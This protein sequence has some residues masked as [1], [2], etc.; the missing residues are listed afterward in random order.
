MNER[1]EIWVVDVGNCRSKAGRFSAAGTLP[2]VRSGP[3]DELL[4]LIGLVRVLSVSPRNLELFLQA[5]EAAP[6]LEL[7]VLGSPLP[8]EFRVAA[9][10]EVGV[11]R[12]ANAAAAWARTKSAAVV[13]DIGTAITVDAVAA[14]GAFLGGAIGPG[15]ATSLAGLRDRAPHLPDPEGGDA[16]SALGGRTRDAM[17]GA[18]RFGFAGLVDRLAEEVASSAKLEAPK[19]YLT[20][21]GAPTVADAVRTPFERVEHLTLEGIFRLAQRLDGVA[22]G[23]KRASPS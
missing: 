13:V 16:S 18:L 15:P 14:D 9:P 2:D 7:E 17:A 3:P 6:D 21:G 22:D 19:F 12:L 4:P 5:H 11:D 23:W 8:I 10:N 1:D 20:G